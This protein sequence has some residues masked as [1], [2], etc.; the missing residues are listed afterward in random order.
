M[1]TFEKVNTNV[2]VLGRE[3]VDWIK[4]PKDT[5]TEQEFEITNKLYHKY[6]IDHDG[7]PKNKIYPDVWYFIN[8]N[9]Q[10]NPNVYLAYIVR[11]KLKSPRKI[12]EH[13]IGMN[14]VGTNESYKGSLICEWAYYQNGSSENPYYMEGCDIATKYLES[15]YPLKNDVFYYVVNTSKGI[16]VFRDEEKSPRRQ[17]I[18]EE[19]TAQMEAADNTETKSAEQPS[20]V[21]EAPAVETATEEKT[22]AA[23]T[24]KQV[25]QPEQA[26]ETQKAVEQ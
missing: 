9:N 1:N 4:A 22:E 20:A 25:E 15:K 23:E 6:M 14:I 24:A 17:Y 13:L 16:R 19:E 11:D 10:F 12:P 2:S 21:E 26:E 5:K 8:H 3:L 18:P 7:K